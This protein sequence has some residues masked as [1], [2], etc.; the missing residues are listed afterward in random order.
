MSN[1]S[2]IV[3]ASSVTVFLLSGGYTLIPQELYDPACNIKGNI[4]YNGGERIYH[5]P[6]QRDYE[7]TRIRM[8][9]GERWFC[10]EDDARVAGWR[11]AGR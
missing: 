9:D 10:S 8:G 4:S 7:S 2:F 6:G 1:F 5:V 11:R 3:A